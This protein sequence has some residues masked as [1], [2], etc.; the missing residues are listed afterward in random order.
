MTTSVVACRG[1]DSRSCRCSV[2]LRLGSGLTSLVS[3]SATTSPTPSATVKPSSTTR[4]TSRSSSSREGQ[5]TLTF[6]TTIDQ[7][8]GKLSQEGPAWNDQGETEL[9]SS[10]SAQRRANVYHWSVRSLSRQAPCS[11]RCRCDCEEQHL[12]D[13]LHLDEVEPE[14]LLQTDR[15]RPADL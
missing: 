9:Y 7:F 6:K 10:T 12:G 1:C 2:A 14:V 13:Q 15:F 4:A 8:G 3:S 11:R 5:G